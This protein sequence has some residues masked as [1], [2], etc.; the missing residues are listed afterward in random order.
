MEVGLTKPIA[1]ITDPCAEELLLESPVEVGLTKLIASST[2]PSGDSRRAR[3]RSRRAR[4]SAGRTDGDSIVASASE[5]HAAPPTLLALPVVGTIVR[6]VG[7]LN[8]AHCHLNS[9]Y[10]II[11]SI[12]MDRVAVAVPGFLPVSVRCTN[13][14]MSPGRPHCKALVTSVEGCGCL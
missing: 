9:A 14:V 1:S 4:L 6:V 7:L 12:M 5:P 13:L 11:T 3:R 2:D 8:E 10:G